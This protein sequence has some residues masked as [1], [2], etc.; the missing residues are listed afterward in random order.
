MSSACALLLVGFAGRAA[1]EPSPADGGQQV[2]VLF[3]FDD[4]LDGWVLGGRNPSFTAR[5]SHQPGTWREGGGAAEIRYQAGEQVLFGTDRFNQG[6]PPSLL[7]R[8]FGGAPA[9]RGPLIDISAMRGVA[10]DVWSEKATTLF[11]IAGERDGSRYV[12]PFGVQAGEWSNVRVPLSAFSLSNDS[13]DENAT[14]DADQIYTFVLGDLRSFAGGDSEANTVYVDSFGILVDPGAPAPGGGAPAAPG[15]SLQVRIRGLRGEVAA[16]LGEPVVVTVQDARGAV[17]ADA[18]E[19]QWSDA[20]SG[21]AVAV[22]DRGAVAGPA[23]SVP[24][25]ERTGLYRVSAR[26]R[27]PD[28]S[29]RSGVSGPIAIVPGG[30]LRSWLGTCV[31]SDLVS[32][33]HPGADGRLARAAG[34]TWDRPIV[35][36]KTIEPKKDTFDWT[37]TDRLID[38]RIGQG[39][40]LAPMVAH[41][42]GWSGSDSSGDAPPQDLDAFTAFAERLVEHYRGRIHHWMVGNEP[43]WGNTKMPA[44][45]YAKLLAAFERG[46]HRADPEVKVLIGGIAFIDLDYLEKLYAAGAGQHFD[47]MSLHPYAFPAEPE[48][49]AGSDLLR[50]TTGVEASLAGIRRVRSL[51]E[52][53]GDAAKPLWITEIA[54]GSGAGEAD[55]EGKFRPFMVDPATQARYYVRAA[56]LARIW[57]AETFFLLSVPDLPDAASQIFARSGVVGLDGSPKP[58]LVALAVLAQQV[59]EARFAGQVPGLPAGAYGAEFETPTERIEVLWTTADS[60]VLQLPGSA[61]GAHLIDLYG[62]DAGPVATGAGESGIEVHVTPEPRYLHLPT[63]SSPGNS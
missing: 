13:S 42:P 43:N 27:G 33:E 30:E 17:G 61:R 52:R 29:T 35:S 14:L 12:H 21:A 58:S 10:L 19:L 20:A 25:P 24:A 9:A 48:A 40:Q 34:I 60:L 54:W 51:M 7:Q 44:A 55:L 28:Q 45:T 26:T 57:G 3:S 59:G 38:E 15:S 1:A 63:A 4:S 39:L 56:V 16:R 37:E 36:W 6:P 41:A 32:V 53:H 62:R 18:V 23:G 47:I 50:R 31:L 49:D 22:P 2:R 46:A 8:V 5:I 11:L